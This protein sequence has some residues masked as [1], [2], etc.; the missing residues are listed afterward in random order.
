MSMIKLSFFGLAIFLM[1]V[2]ETICRDAKQSDC[3]PSKRGY[4]AEVVHVLKSSERQLN[5]FLDVHA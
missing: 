1:G 3:L 5:Y 2:P 4:L